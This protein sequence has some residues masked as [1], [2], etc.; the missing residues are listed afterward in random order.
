MCHIVRMSTRH[1]MIHLCGEY[2]CECSNYVSDSG[3][4]QARHGGL[5][6]RKSA[7]PGWDMSSNALP[8]HSRERQLAAHRAWAQLRRR[9]WAFGDEAIL[10][11]RAIM[12]GFWGRT[13][14]GS[15]L[16]TSGGRCS[17]GHCGGIAKQRQLEGGALRRTAAS[18][19][20][21]PTYINLVRRGEFLIK[22]NSP[23]LSQSQTLFTK[24]TPTHNMFSSLALFASLLPLSALGAPVDQDPKLQSRTI[25]D[26]SSLQ[27]RDTCYDY[28]IMDYPGGYDPTG[29]RMVS[30]IDNINTNLQGY[31]GTTFLTQHNRELS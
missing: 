6:S 27:S 23:R 9:W 18:V 24:Y 10:A 30:T 19:R 26:T 1:C 12:P 25:P 31:S 20:Q 15:Q 29:N 8:P 3:A 21:L 2:Y 14:R 22:L 28:V 11:D 16:P 5:S 7:E 17:C 4:G 13:L